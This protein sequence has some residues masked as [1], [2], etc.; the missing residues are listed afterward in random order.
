MDGRYFDDFEL[1]EEFET[2]ARTITEADVVQF[3]GLSGDFNPL[4]TDE[5]YAKNGRFGGRIAHGLLGLAVVSGL[6]SRLGFYEGTVI[7]FLSLN[8]KF[9]GPIRPGDTI[10]AR[11]KIAGKRETSKADRGVLVQWI[12][13][14][15]QR[16]E[17]VQEGEQVLLMKRRT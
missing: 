17:V 5:E 9:V 6:K 11:V 8:W 4:H 3:A 1:G 15:N 7:A 14:T 10:R 2:P 16:G 13:V 12:T